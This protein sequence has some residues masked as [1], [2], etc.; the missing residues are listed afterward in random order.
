MKSLLDIINSLGA[1]PSTI[2]RYDIC[3]GVAYNS[4]YTTE[5]DDSECANIL[6]V[7]GKGRIIGIVPFTSSSSFYG[8]IK[9]YLDNKKMLAGSCYYNQN[10][11]YP[12]LVSKDFWDITEGHRYPNYQYDNY[13]GLYIPELNQSILYTSGTYYTIP[14]RKDYN[15]DNYVNGANSYPIFFDNNT[16]GKFENN[17]KILATQTQTSGE[18]KHIRVLVIYELES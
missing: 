17:L 11:G 2:R 7:K 14:Y 4:T 15:R 5:I 9:V 13:K 10:A 6:E 16:E 3:T 18:T 1:N 8:T 12:F